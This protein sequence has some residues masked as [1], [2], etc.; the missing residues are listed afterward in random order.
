MVAGAV[1]HRQRPGTAGGV[2]FLSLEDETGLINIIVS[3]GLWQRQRKL[4]N[5]ALAMIVRG[6]LQIADGSINL[7]ADQL[8]PLDLPARIRSRDF[9]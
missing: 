8:R 2:T 5:T 6:Q 4:A 3:Q 9:H 7:V 1:T